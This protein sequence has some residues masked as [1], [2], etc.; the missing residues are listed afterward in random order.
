MARKQF[1]LKNIGPIADV[2]VEFGDLTVL[3]GPQATGKS[4]FLQLF[5]LAVDA[6]YITTRLKESGLDWEKDFGQFLNLY[7]GEGMEKTWDPAKSG[8]L[9]DGKRIDP[10]KLLQRPEKSDESL[11]FIPAQRVM[12]LQNGWPKTFLDYAIYD[13][14]V[15]R[16]F[17]HNILRFMLSFEIRSVDKNIF[18][19]DRK[20]EK[21]GRDALNAAIFNGAEL[22]L[23]RVGPQRRLMLK[24]NDE[25]LPF[26]VW[27]AGQREFVPLLL[28]VYQLFPSYNTRMKKGIEW[29]VIEELEMGL[30]PRAIFAV[31]LLVLEMLYRGYKVVLST[32]SNQVLDVIW[33]IQEIKSQH[34]SADFLLELFNCPKENGIRKMAKEVLAKEFKVYSFQPE[35]TGVSAKDISMLDPG[36]NDIQESGW[37]GLSEFS[38]HVADLVGK[39]YHNSQGY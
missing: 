34:A 28:G 6:G 21:A 32:H 12:T 20:L 1:R 35:Q 29:V 17:S 9:L 13:P 36:S 30:H 3:V 24:V 2:N 7:L 10:R 15:V 5:K 31:M 39:V 27:S 16:S 18:P 14:F 8:I 4:I 23:D 22:L 33:A 37:G 25:K 38:G 11:Y 26:M 19:M